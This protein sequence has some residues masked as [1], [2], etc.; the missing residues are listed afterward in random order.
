MYYPHGRQGIDGLCVLTETNA[1]KTVRYES[2]ERRRWRNIKPFFG[3]SLTK[4]G[5]W[6]DECQEDGGCEKCVEGG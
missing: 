6:M 5:G 3:R 2:V 1:W 4:I